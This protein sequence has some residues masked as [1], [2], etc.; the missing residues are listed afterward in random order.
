MLG[1]KGPI[2]AWELFFLGGDPNYPRDS[3]TGAASTMLRRQV[4]LS[5]SQPRRMPKG[6]GSLPRDGTVHELGRLWHHI[7]AEGA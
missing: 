7:K 2:K 3:R 1:L 4:A 6:G 5:L